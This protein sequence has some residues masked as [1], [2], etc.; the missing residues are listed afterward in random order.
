MAVTVGSWTAIDDT[1]VD[2]DSPITES[3]MKRNRDNSY[4][5][6]AGTRQTTQTNTSKLLT[7]DGAGGVQWVDASTVSQINGTKGQ[8]TMPTT[9]GSPLVVAIQTGRT[10]EVSVFNGPSAQT[11]NM[12]SGRIIV[13]ASDDSISY[14]GNF[15]D[16][17][18]NTFAFSTGN[19]TLG[20]SFANYLI[21][22]RDSAPNDTFI[23]VR[24]NGTDY[25]F[26]VNQSAGG[27]GT[28]CYQY[29]WL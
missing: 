23:A 14:A 1:E 28:S 25:E 11:N 20:A 19:A 3:L 24:K 2:V 21:I 16:A 18:G 12:G 13:D 10:L 6:D 9:S 29:L 22:D 5:I 15:F 4:W 17:S 7:P 27:S 8:G 26:Y